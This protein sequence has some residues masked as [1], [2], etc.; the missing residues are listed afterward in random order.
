MQ[1]YTGIDIVENKR[2]KQA[3]NKLGEKFL[4]RVF[5]K[6]ELEYCLT[7]ANSIPCL[8]ARFAAKEAAIKAFYQAFKEKL[9]LKQIEILGKSGHPAEILLH[10]PKDKKRAFNIT[11]SLAHENNYSTAIVILYL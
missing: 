7:K 10:L 8:A 9:S 2:I 4:N 3:I 1:I 6:N 5:T 11:L